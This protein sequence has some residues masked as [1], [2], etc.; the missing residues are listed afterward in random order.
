MRHTYIALF[1]DSVANGLGVGP[2]R[3]GEVVAASLDA[4]LLDF[5]G[6]AQPVSQSSM[7]AQESLG[8]L[9]V[10]LALVAHGITEAMVRPSAAHLRGMPARW[11][12]LGWMDPRPYYSRRWW[13]SA[14]QRLESA[15]RWRAKNF[16]IRRDGGEQLMT[17]P[18]YEYH[19]RNLV[20]GLV[21]PTTKVLVIGPPRISE[22]YFPGSNPQLQAYADTSRLVAHEM[23]ATYVEIAQHL[24]PGA[25]Y[26]A[27]QFH[28]SALGHAKIAALILET[29]P[30]MRA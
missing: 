1:G 19:L 23:G 4:K 29:L 22:R 11:R 5:S 2:R 30:Q 17:R 24:A 9:N 20:E 25:D 3:Y 8:N 13:K 18:A 7:L 16:L 12:R 6:S 27:D 10:V 15:V 28:P 21:T 14:G 26:L